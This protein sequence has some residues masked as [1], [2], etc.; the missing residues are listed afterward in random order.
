[1][2]RE[3]ATHNP[4]DW[5][6]KAR[7]Y[8]ESFLTTHSTGKN[9]LGR[10]KKP[11]WTEQDFQ[12]LLTQLRYYGYSWL[13]PEVLRRKLKHMAGKWQGPSSQPRT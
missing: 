10:W 12:Q 3:L 4:A 5:D 11:Q 8:L 2:A 7:L 13:Q 9:W 6:E 1:M